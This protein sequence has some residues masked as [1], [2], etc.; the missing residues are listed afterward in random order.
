MGPNVVV[1]VVVVVVGV[2]FRVCIPACDS[3]VSVGPTEGT[4]IGLEVSPADV[5]LLV[6]LDVVI[7]IIVVVVVVVATDA[8]GERGYPVDWGEVA[9]SKMASSVMTRGCRVEIAAFSDD[10]IAAFLVVAAA[11]SI[12]AAVAALLVVAAA[13]PR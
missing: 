5:V 1:V 3:L 2:I 12:D 11:A 10:T 4:V 7:I 8:I 6:V 9:S 13:A